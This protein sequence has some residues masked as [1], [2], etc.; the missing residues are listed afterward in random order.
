MLLRR[1]ACVSVIVWGLALSLSSAEP[2]LSLGSLLGSATSYQAHVVTV[3]GTAKEIQ[4]LPAFFGGGKCG[5]V[6]DS[7]LFTLEDGTGSVRVEVFGVC[8][9]AGAIAP[10]ADGEEVQLQG[11]FI[12][13]YSGVDTAPLIY[14]N[15]F[16]VKRLAN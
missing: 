16:A 12:V 3:R 6:H 9:M 1:I 2:T 5:M 10:V 7:Y 13:H 4:R 15:T 11:L 8:R 14:T